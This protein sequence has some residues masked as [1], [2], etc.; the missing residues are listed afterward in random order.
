MDLALDK[1]ESLLGKRRNFRRSNS[2][3]SIQSDQRAR[4]PGV[5]RQGACCVGAPCYR[6]RELQGV[7]VNSRAAFPR[8]DQDG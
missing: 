4:V 1:T 2:W 3:H 5:Q 6:R 7:A 8:T